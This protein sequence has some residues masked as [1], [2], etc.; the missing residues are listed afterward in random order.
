MTYLSLVE[1]KQSLSRVLNAY[2]DKNKNLD[3]AYLERS[4]DEV[5]AIVNASINNR[6][7]IPA[8]ST[9]AVTFLRSLVIAILKYNSYAIIPNREVPKAVEGA[10]ESAMGTVKMLSRQT[11]SLPGESE[12]TTDGS[13]N[14]YLGLTEQTDSIS[15]Y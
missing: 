8:T 4:I 10:Y 12:K 7:T 9:A 1:A 15:G 11:I 6:Y 3:E 5:E 13:R 2:D 14:S